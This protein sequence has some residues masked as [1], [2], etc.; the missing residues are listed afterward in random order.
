MSWWKVWHTIIYFFI[1]G[2]PTSGGVRG[3]F[4]PSWALLAW[5]T[6]CK[7]LLHFCQCSWPWSCDFPISLALEFLSVLQRIILV[8]NKYTTWSYYRNISLFVNELLE[9]LLWCHTIA[10]SWWQQPNWQQHALGLW[11]LSSNMAAITMAKTRYYSSECW[12]QPFCPLMRGCH[13]RRLR[14]MCP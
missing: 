4:W 13:V 8:W 11:R 7:S 14:K 9:V 12:N 3:S 2:L 1:V 5:L 10:M 6:L